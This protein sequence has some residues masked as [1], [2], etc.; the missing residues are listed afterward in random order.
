MDAIKS[1]IAP[2]T[3]QQ[4]VVL[5]K[6]GT[7]LIIMADEG[8]QDPL[9]TITLDGTVVIIDDQET[10]D[11]GVPM[12]IFIK[13]LYNKSVPVQTTSR[14][15]IRD[16]MMKFQ[17]KDGKFLET[18]GLTYQGKQ[19]GLNR[20]LDYYNIGPDS[21][22]FFTFGLRGGG[23]RGLS[24]SGRKANPFADEEIMTVMAA[25]G[26]LFKQATDSALELI[27][28]TTD[29]V[30]QLESMAVADIKS[31]VDQIRHGKHH[32]HV[33]VQ[34]VVKAIPGMLAMS[35][36]AKKLDGSFSI[37]TTNLSKKLWDHVCS[38][39]LDGKFSVEVLVRM[40]TEIG[41]K[42]GGSDMEL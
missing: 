15:V 35:L 12:T 39:T 29:V 32:I 5:L 38:G 31:A 40:L 42:K 24:S 30:K 23:K 4:L 13:D 37:I 20:R 19:L 14:A 36:A 17:E 7:P 16:V 18:A 33:K 21:N 41:K 25:D 3:L 28:D 10:F 34:N 27:K 11:E 6:T 8:V 22:V 1:L 26:P 2:E 9:E